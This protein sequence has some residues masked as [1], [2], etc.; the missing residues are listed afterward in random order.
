MM[1]IAVGEVLTMEPSMERPQEGQIVPICS[2]DDLKLFT[3]T[4]VSCMEDAVLQSSVMCLF[5]S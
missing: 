5:G 1:V 2:S 3:H 4:A